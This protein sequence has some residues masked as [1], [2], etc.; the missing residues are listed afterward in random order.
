MSLLLVRYALT[1]CMQ[2]SKVDEDPKAKENWILKA[3]YMK[4]KVGESLKTLQGNTDQK[5]Q[6][7]ALED[8][9]KVSRQ[10]FGDKY[11]KFCL[12]KAVKTI[13]QVHARKSEGAQ[14]AAAGRGESAGGGGA[15]SSQAD[16]ASPKGPANKGKGGKKRKADS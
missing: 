16:R 1:I 9:I 11:V 12:A 3:K 8:V 4:Y 10:L 7:S 13:R 2:R 14:A 15:E 5:K 6:A